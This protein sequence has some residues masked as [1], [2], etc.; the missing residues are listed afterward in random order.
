MSAHLP[1]R[2][3]LALCPLLL[4]LATAPALAQITVYEHPDFG[5]R[6]VSTD[7][8]LRN[9]RRSGLNDRGSSVVVRGQRWEICDERSFQ[10]R[11]KLLR[12]GQYPS[13]EAMGMDDA[14]SSVRRVGRERADDRPRYAP[15]PVV[16]VDYRR[17]N[18]ERLYEARVSQ[19]RAVYGDAEQRCWMER[20]QAEVQPRQDGRVPG[21]LFGAV[22]GGILGHQVGGGSGRDLATAGGV[23]AGAVVGAN[24]GRNRDG[25]TVVTRDVQRCRNRQSS[26][27]PVY[28]DVDYEF[29]GRAHQMQMQS[30]PG[31]TITVNRQG[32]PRS[33]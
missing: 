7:S 14:I 8:E 10:G 33:R 11:C 28:W 18:G 2:P 3:W 20:G 9:L 26:N 12:P 5:G 27:R 17:R 19:V 32:E 21:A 6:S 13:L 25:E 4:A 23:V 15:Y 1:R 29:R 16:P 24:L 22:I 31:D 30:P